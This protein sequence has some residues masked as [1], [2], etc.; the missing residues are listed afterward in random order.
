MERLREL[1]PCTVHAALHFA[2]GRPVSMMTD[3]GGAAAGGAGRSE[4]YGGRSQSNPMDASRARRF[5]RSIIN[6]SAV[7]T[8]RRARWLPLGENCMA[9][10]GWLL[11]KSKEART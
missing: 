11:G 9:A 7:F 8:P 4:G 3:N 1:N 10:T 5:D 6:T 2:S